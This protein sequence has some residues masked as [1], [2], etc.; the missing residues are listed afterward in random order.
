MATPPGPT[1]W[2][3]G[4]GWPDAGP[5]E[6]ITSAPWGS[7]RGSRRKVPAAQT[8]D[9]PTQ[10]PTVRGGELWPCLLLPLSASGCEDMHDLESHREDRR[11][12]ILL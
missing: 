2:G 10:R 7:E 12:L 8:P 3:T 11:S 9:T 4:P 1:Q 5:R 6:S